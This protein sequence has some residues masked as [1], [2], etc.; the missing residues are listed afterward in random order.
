MCFGEQIIEEQKRRQ[1]Y[2]SLFSYEGYSLL[3][4]I[5]SFREFDLIMKSWGL[6]DLHEGLG[7]DEIYNQVMSYFNHLSFEGLIFQNSMF[8]A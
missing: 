2:G 4:E 8:S 5:K 1:E 7:I 6:L 3:R